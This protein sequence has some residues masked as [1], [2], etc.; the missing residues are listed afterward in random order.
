MVFT[1]LNLSDE[2]TIKDVNGRAHPMTMYQVILILVI[3]WVSFLLSWIFNLIY[4]KVHP[5]A[6]DFN[7]GRSKAKLF[8]YF[9]GRKVKLPGY[10]D[11][12]ND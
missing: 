3:G 12:K 2:M 9:F 8:L 11:E 6:V 5:S 1:I 7:F 4:Y 10:K